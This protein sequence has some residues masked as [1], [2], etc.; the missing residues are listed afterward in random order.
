LCKFGRQ[1]TKRHRLPCYHL[2]QVRYSYFG[3]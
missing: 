3:T 2:R 1:A